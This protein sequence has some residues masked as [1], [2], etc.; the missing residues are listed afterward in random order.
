MQ[1][2]RPGERRDRLALVA[3]VV[4]IPGHQGVLDQ[5]DRGG[6]RPPGGRGAAQL[7]VGG[8][9]EDGDEVRQGVR[10]GAADGDRAAGKRGGTQVSGTGPAV[11]GGC[12]PITSDADSALG[13]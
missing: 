1:Q 6:Q 4:V 3:A 13:H 8:E 5:P 11:L 7:A 2:H 12:G 9:L 10:A